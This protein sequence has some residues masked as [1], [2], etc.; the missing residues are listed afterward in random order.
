MRTGSNVGN[1]NNRVS[2]VIIT[3]GRV[4]GLMKTL[5][6]LC[7]QTFR[8]FEVCVVCGPF[9]DG[10]EEFIRERAVRFGIKWSLCDRA[11]ISEAR[12][13]GVKLAAGDLVAFIDDDAIPEPVWLQQLTAAFDCNSVAGASGLVIAPNGRDYQF[14]YSLCDR[15][16]D[17]TYDLS[18]PAD[19]YAFPFSHRFPHAM[20]TNCMFRRAAIVSIGGFDEEFDYYLDE[21]DLCCRLIDAGLGFKQL[22]NAPV[23]HKYLPSVVR[24]RTRKEVSYYSTIKNRIYFPLVNGRSHLSINEILSSV[25]AFIAERRRRLRQGVPELSDVDGAASTFEREVERAWDV[26]LSRGLSRE[27][28]LPAKGF[29]D[30]PAPFRTYQPGATG[31]VINH[32]VIVLPNHDMFSELFVDAQIEARDKAQSG[33]CVRVIAVCNADDPEAEG[34]D[35]LD[36]IWFHRVLPRRETSWRISG[37][38]QDDALA[39]QALAVQSEISRIQALQSVDIVE[40][41][42]VSRLSVVGLHNNDGA[43]LL[44]PAGALVR[45][46]SNCLR[47]GSSSGQ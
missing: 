2:V 33:H 32:V 21:A 6:A 26:G 3:N 25:L 44:P 10:T 45:V 15:S 4:L 20:G 38:D 16:G 46:R 23:H 5:D 27:R 36:G 40:D 18:A 29:F 7:H 39:S 11:N 14:R 12:N 43:K 47:D 41:W 9:G 34:V 28:R 35:I 42:S 1:Y 31:N 24:D 22:G 19:E 8:D 17:A 13:L 30:N 37:A